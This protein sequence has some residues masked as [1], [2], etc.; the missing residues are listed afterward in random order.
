MTVNTSVLAQVAALEGMETTALKKMWLDLFDADPPPYNKRF[1]V[2]RLSYRMQELA[3]GGLSKETVERLEAIA[4]DGAPDERNRGRGR[5]AERPVVG[6]RL[7]REWN[8]VEHH[9]TV[10]ADSFEWQGKKYKSL[11]AVARSIT[12]TRWN[13]PLFFGMRQHGNGK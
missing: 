4:G 8:G 1:L 5:A 13:G 2:S 3:F 12:G 9:V 10:Q 11:S 6:T 7:I